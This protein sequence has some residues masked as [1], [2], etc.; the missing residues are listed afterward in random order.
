[1]QNKQQ[2]VQG[3]ENRVNKNRKGEE[4]EMKYNKEDLNTKRNRREDDEEEGDEY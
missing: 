4:E 2:E 1:M 3:K